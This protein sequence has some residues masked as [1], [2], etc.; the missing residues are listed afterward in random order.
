M[1]RDERDWL[2]VVVTFRSTDCD[3]SSSSLGNAGA[4]TGLRFLKV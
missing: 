4:Q 2:L 3:A 1:H